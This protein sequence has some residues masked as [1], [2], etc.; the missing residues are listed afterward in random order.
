MHRY[1]NSVKINLKKFTTTAL[2]QKKLP[3]T[4][5]Q[6]KKCIKRLTNFTSNW[7]ELSKKR[8]TKLFQQYFLKVRPVREKIVNFT[9][10][11]L[12]TY[13][14]LFNILCKFKSYII[15]THAQTTQLCWILSRWIREHFY[16]NKLQPVC[17][18]DWLLYTKTNYY[19]GGGGASHLTLHCIMMPAKT[20]VSHR[21][22]RFAT[23]DVCTSATEIPYLWRK[24][25]PE[26]GSLI[27]RRSN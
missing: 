2:G 26:S 17:V 23:S 1:N 16:V 18:G 7:D 15:Y 10:K 5:K 11:N 9:L 27:G 14:H 20:A 22:R 19:R 24:F 13:L 3:L 4:F 6:K 21:L 25:C 12:L 8:I